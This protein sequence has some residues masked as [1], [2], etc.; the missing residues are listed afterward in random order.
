MPWT[1]PALK[2]GFGQPDPVDPQQEG[3]LP[4]TRSGLKGAHLAVKVGER[5]GV[6]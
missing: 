2:L 3:I 4:R 5:Q 6:E 1:A